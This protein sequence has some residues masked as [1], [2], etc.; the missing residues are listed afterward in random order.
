V[1]SAKK[2]DDP[3]RAYRGYIAVDDVQFQPID[4]AEDKC[5]GCSK[6]YNFPFGNYCYSRASNQLN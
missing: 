6:F 3:E 4:E 1:A 2:I 5:K